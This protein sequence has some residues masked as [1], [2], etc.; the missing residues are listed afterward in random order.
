MLQKG[1][2][3]KFYIPAD[4]INISSNQTKRCEF[5]QQIHACIVPIFSHFYVGF[6]TN[7][8]K[9]LLYSIDFNM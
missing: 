7:D 5:P 2:A 8:L 9:T 6:L 1:I 4:T 3:S